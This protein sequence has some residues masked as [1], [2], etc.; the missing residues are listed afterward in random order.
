MNDTKGMIIKNYAMHVTM[1]FLSLLV[2]F[3]GNSILGFIFGALIYFTYVMLQYGDGADRG[4]KACTLTATVQKLESENKNVDEMLKKQMF[5][6]KRAICAFLA[7]S[8]PFAI[9]AILNLVFADP[10]S[11]S[12]NLLGSI[13]RIVF[14]PA[15]WLNRILMEL[16]GWDLEGLW[17]SSSNIFTAFLDYGEGLELS[18]LP[19]T[20]NTTATFAK[21]YDVFYIT[22]LRCTFIVMAFIPPAA[23]MIG[24]FQGPKLREKKLKEIAKGTRKKRKKLKVFGNKHNG[25]KQA[26]PE[27]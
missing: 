4:E 15:A 9:L 1:M 24:Y 16:V 11:V 10:N 19:E 25:P 6:K 23:Q 3:V 12:E 8:L 20:L 21:A 5:S 7:S 17:Q 26:K 27:V 18:L 14:L 22:I 2:T 13:T